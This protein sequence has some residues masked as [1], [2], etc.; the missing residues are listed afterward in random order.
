MMPKEKPDNGVSI[1]FYT[2]NYFWKSNTTIFSLFY[3]M[4]LWS[5]DKRT[6]LQLHLPAH[7]SQKSLAKSA[8]PWTFRPWLVSSLRLQSKNETCHT[9]VWGTLSCHICTLVVL[10]HQLG[11]RMMGSGPRR[12]CSIGGCCCQIRLLLSSLKYIYAVAILQ[13]RL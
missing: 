2:D 13:Y 6:P 3:L 5:W 4:T 12:K 9:L 10:K 1:Q 11:P 7:P 8:P